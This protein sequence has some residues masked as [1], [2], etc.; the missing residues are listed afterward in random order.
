MSESNRVEMAEA[1]TPKA[2][3]NWRQAYLWP[4]VIAYAANCVFVWALIALDDLRSGGAEPIL[5]AR[6]GMALG[7][8]AL[9]AWLAAGWVMIARHEGMTGKRASRLVRA[10]CWVLTSLAV[11][12]VAVHTLHELLLWSRG[13]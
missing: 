13:R 3:V 2:G 8:G 12:S 1:E 5:C 9:G 4:V 10:V 11:L 7:I 6:V